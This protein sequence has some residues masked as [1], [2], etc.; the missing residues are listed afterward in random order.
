MVV[1]LYGLSLLKLFRVLLV[2]SQPGSRVGILTLLDD[3]CNF[4]KGDDSKFLEKL[5]KCF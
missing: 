5:G 4:P 2:F 1:L 3:V